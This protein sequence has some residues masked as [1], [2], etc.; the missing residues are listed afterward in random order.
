MPRS[1]LERVLV[2]E[3]GPDWRGR[4]RDFDFSP[5]AAASIGQVH[6]AVTLDGDLVAMKVQYPGV[7]RSIDRCGANERNES[8]EGGRWCN[9]LW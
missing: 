9:A 4:L 8:K 5:F 7:A 6:R 3:L 1:Q 2:S